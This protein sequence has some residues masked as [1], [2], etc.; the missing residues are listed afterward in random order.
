MSIIYLNVVAE[1]GGTYKG[2]IQRLTDGYYR[3]DDAETFVS[4]PAW[5]DKDITMYEGSGVNIGSYTN[6]V[7]ASGWNDG[8]YMFRAHDMLAGSGVVASTLFSV[9][10]GMEV[11]IGEEYYVYYAD[12][13]YNKDETNIKDEYT[14]IWFKNGIPITSG[15]TSPT[16]QVIKRD[17]T[18]LISPVAM[19]QIGTT[20]YYKY[21]ELANRQTMGES[22]V[23]ICTATI[24]GAVR[25]YGVVQGVGVNA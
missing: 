1:S 2:T 24:D 21:D 17:G 5:A 9:R 13:F 20:G 12:I 7:Q 19:T 4:A 8:V 23:I 25:T 16:I 11:Q 18:S 22:Y 10:S 14:M 15:I 3:E 6:T